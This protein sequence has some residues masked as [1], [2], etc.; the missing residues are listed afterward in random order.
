MTESDSAD[1]SFRRSP[2]PIAAIGLGLLA[3]LKSAGLTEA[4]PFVRAMG[5][6]ESRQGDLRDPT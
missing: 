3:M 4:R 2:W 6:S 1:T 5:L